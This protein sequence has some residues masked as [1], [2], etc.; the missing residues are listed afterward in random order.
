MPPIIRLVNLTKIY[1]QPGFLKPKKIV[2]VEDLTLDIEDG[3][4]FGLLGLNGSGKTT[5]M[6]LLLGL[7]RPTLGTA[8]IRAS[9]GYLP[10]NIHFPGNLTAYEILKF[11]SFDIG[12]NPA[13]RIGEVLD[14]AGISAYARQSV[15][16]FSKGMTQRLGIAQAILSR[17]KLL[18]LDE[19]TSGLD[20]LGVVELRKLFLRL[21]EEFK[22]T[23][24]FSSHIV[25]EVEKI[26]HRVGILG[27]NRLRGVFS[28]EAWSREKTLEDIFVQTVSG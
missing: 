3:E 7:I 28:R 16:G 23:I 24:L 27:G 21:N 17:P 6:R 19:P 25:S 13:G 12:E 9:A 14:I 26:S 20:P 18:V 11:L 10:E 5:T 4:V 15:G 1:S 8:Q 22:I 2:G